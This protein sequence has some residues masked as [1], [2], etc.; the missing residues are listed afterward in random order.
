MKAY[1]VTMKDW[2]ELIPT[3]A[4]CHNSYKEARMFVIKGYMEVYN[5]SFLEAAKGVSLKRAKQYD[6][7]ANRQKEPAHHAMD[8]VCDSMKIG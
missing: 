1:T 8:Y 4:V 2:G 5:R 7:W 6:E 3:S